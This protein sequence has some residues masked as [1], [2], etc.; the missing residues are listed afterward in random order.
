[1][2]LDA[3][4]GSDPRIRIVRQPVNGGISSAS[5]AA[6]ALA[7][8]DFVALLDHDDEITP[9]A[10]LEVAEELNRHPDADVVYTDE[11]KLDFDGTHIEPFFKPDWSPEYLKST[12]FLGHLVVYR[13][14]VLEAVGGFRSAFDGSQD[15]DLALRVTERTGKV[16][17]VPR[18]LYHWR[19]IQGSAASSAD[20][21]PWGLQ[22]ARRALVD[23]VSRLTMRA[24]VQDEPGDGFWRVRYEIV[25][26]PKVSVIIPHGRDDPRDAVGPPRHA[27]R[28]RA[29]DSRANRLP[30]LRD[31]ARSERTGS[32]VS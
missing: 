6:L 9:D 3:L 20:A 29:L 22:A 28:L 10:L 7:D 30:A 25:G 18:V 1:M 2:A 15:Y 11:D 23:H 24:S 27:A 32:P 4:D 17:H 31:R 26:T 5:N 21:K 12:M 14:S 19:K 16:H 8:G 13:R